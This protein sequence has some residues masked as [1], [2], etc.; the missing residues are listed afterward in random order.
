[1]R[2]FA[3]CYLLAFLLGSLLLPIMPVFA[4]SLEHLSIDELISLDI[5]S[6]QKKEEPVSSTAAAIFVITQQDIRRSG[7]TTIP[8]LLRMVPGVH[9]GRIENT[10]WAV[11]IRGFNGRFS[12]KLLVL[13]DGRSIYNPLFSGVD[14]EQHDIMLENIARIEVI[15]GP[16]STVWGANAVNGVINVITKDSAETLGPLV[17]VLG[18]N[19]ELFTGKMRYGGELGENSSYRLWGKQTFRDD[20]KIS[21]FGDPSGDA[22]DSLRS[23][24]A[25]FRLDNTPSN[26]DTLRLSGD[27]GLRNFDETTNIDEALDPLFVPVSDEIDHISGHLLGHWTHTISENS[28]L[29]FQV[30]W[31]SYEEDTA[32]LDF[33][34][35]A[36]DF[37]FQHRFSP[38]ENHDLVWGGNYRNQ[39]YTDMTGSIFMTF[40][41]PERRVDLYT[42]FIQDEIELLPD[43]LNLIV[44]SKF[45]DNATSGFEVMPNIRMAWTPKKNLTLWGAVSRSVRTPSL[46]EE[47]ARLLD[48]AFM[49]GETPTLF[50]IN[51]DRDLDAE[52][53]M[54]YELGFRTQVRENLSLDV[55]VFFNDY[56]DIVNGVVDSFNTVGPPPRQEIDGIIVNKLDADTYGAELL[57]DWRPIERWRLI[58]SYSFL[59]AN[60][61]GDEI[62]R[63]AE[64]EAP[65][66]QGHIRSQLNVREDISFDLAYRI[67]DEV[68]VGRQAYKSDLYHELDARLAWKPTDA[69]EIAAVGQN[70]L[71]E[72]HTEWVEPYFARIPQKLER[73]FYAELTWTP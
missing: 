27:I 56:S 2:Q 57:V 67:V 52:N 16:G 62:F 12:N 35:S 17:S 40:D 49:A 28:D 1:M 68:K 8:E 14:W 20:S 23:S 54:A 7:A 13:I 45:E 71:H 44:G 18:G 30:Y 58:G 66:H 11:G 9:V 19:E 50:F 36:L 43:E 37:D 73:G 60:I 38:I 6:A 31:D 59:Q 72:D 39:R 24:R 47:S 46:A 63:D 61:I 64:S 69:W 53:L 3:N 15:R 34:R 32:Q 65:S 26:K 70:L 25:G 10:S 55:A 33:T 42:A 48:D 22:G 51:G 4:E 41:P 5:T 21:E 29:Q